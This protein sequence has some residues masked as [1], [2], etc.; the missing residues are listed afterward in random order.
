[1]LG[2]QDTEAEVRLAGSTTS[3]GNTQHRIRQYDSSSSVS[4]IKELRFAYGIRYQDRLQQKGREKLE[5]SAA[6]AEGLLLLLLLVREE[7]FPLL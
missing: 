5:I 3:K 6:G 2:S 1:M 4:S 7:A